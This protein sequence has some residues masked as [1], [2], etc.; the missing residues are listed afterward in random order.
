M[1]Q[2]KELESNGGRRIVGSRIIAATIEGADVQ[3]LSDNDPVK[4][5]FVTVEVSKLV[6]DN[7]RVGCSVI[8]QL[9]KLIG[10]GNT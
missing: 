4:S 2:S 1:K 3:G 7:L 5:V 8:S 9:Y 10:S 6:Q